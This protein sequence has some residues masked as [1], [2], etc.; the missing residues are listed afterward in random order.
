MTTRRIPYNRDSSVDIS[1]E[2]EKLR[3]H[4]ADL[5]VEKK[6]KDEIAMK[7]A[8]NA[9][10]SKTQLR[11]YREGVNKLSSQKLEEAMKKANNRYLVDLRSASSPSQICDRLYKEGMTKKLAE[12]GRERERDQNGP[13][14]SS[15]KKITS[16][17]LHDRLYNEDM[18][19]IRARNRSSS[20]SMRRESPAQQA[21]KGL[22]GRSSSSNRIHRPREATLRAAS[23]NRLPRS[24]NKPEN[25]GA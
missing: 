3:N 11:L 12:R 21:S 19:K 20:H 23:K 10:P 9:E 16:S 18:Q 6:V 2:L 1:S 4:Y 22:R 24:F 14:P 25:V 5:K 7:K 8:M 15:R 17:P 13:S